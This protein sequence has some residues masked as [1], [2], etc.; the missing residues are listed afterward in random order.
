[1]TWINSEKLLNEWQSSLIANRN[2][3]LFLEWSTYQSLCVIGS[4]SVITRSRFV[5][6]G[7]PMGSPTTATITSPIRPILVSRA[8]SEPAVNMF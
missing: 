7:T 5:V 6:P 4:G 1:M 3:S 2:I 8:K